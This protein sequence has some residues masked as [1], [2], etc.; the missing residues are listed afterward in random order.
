M[1]RLLYFCISCIQLA[2]CYCI[3]VTMFNATKWFIKILFDCIHL[4]C[5]CNGNYDVHNFHTKAPI[6]TT[7]LLSSVW[8]ENYT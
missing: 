8:Y 1:I 5:H 7:L 2:F 4:T 6:P 3:T